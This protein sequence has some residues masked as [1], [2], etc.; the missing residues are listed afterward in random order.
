M[1]K[2]RRDFFSRP[3]PSGVAHT[4]AEKLLRDCIF[5]VRRKHLNYT[6]TREKREDG[7]P[8]PSV[9]VSPDKVGSY[10]LRSQGGPRRSELAPGSDRKQGNVEILLCYFS[11]FF[12]LL[13]PSTPPHAQK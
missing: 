6:F 2:Q 1:G 4:A 10:P 3:P 12:F 13:L 11:K 7:W 5:P 9:H 8:E